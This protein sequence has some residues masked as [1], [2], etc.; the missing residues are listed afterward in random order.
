MPILRENFD[1]EIFLSELQLQCKIFEH[2][3]AR[4]EI[5]AEHWVKAHNGIDDG[6]RFSP[7]E[8]IAECTVCLSAMS[9]IR[10]ILCPRGPNLTKQSRSRGKVLYDLLQRP[11]ITSIS[12]SVVRN[13]WEHHDEKLDSILSKR[14]V[15]N[16]QLTQLHISPEP[17]NQG[18]IVLRRF[19]PVNL[20][21]YFSGN[22]VPLR[23]SMKEIQN[24]K[25][26][27]QRSYDV[28]QSEIIKISP[29]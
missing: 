18:T 23:P 24:L 2:A 19:D 4:L 17:P 20:V 13:S 27:I 15:G 16:T 21:I 25:K 26:E 29:L 8:I 10:K 14:E 1:V 12:Q 9:A 3:I 22:A 28:L 11:D 6:G 7:L 5:A